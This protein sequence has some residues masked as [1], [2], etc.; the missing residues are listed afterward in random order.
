MTIYFIAYGILIFMYCAEKIQHHSDAKKKLTISFFIIFTIMLGFRHPSMG[1]DLGYGRY[2]GYLAS[3][4]QFQKMSWKEVLDLNSFLN[5]EK[6]VCVYN[7]VLGL[8]SKD[9]QILLFV[10]ALISLF[11]IAATFYKLGDNHNILIDNYYLYSIAM[12]FNSVFWFE[13]KYSHFNLRIFIA[14]Y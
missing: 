9:P 8:I 4:E 13:A 10:T 2:Y 3:F 1:V 5:Y 12:L 6:W 7:K 14:L 11:L